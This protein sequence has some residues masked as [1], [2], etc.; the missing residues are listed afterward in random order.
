MSDVAW[1]GVVAPDGRDEALKMFMLPAN[2]V[3]VRGGHQIYSHEGAYYLY[4]PGVGTWGF[5]M[6]LDGA[7]QAACSVSPVES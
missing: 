4:T 5:G 3:D 6:S 2:L 7:I 1:H